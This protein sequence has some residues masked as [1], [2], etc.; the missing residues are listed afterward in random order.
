MGQKVTLD[1]ATMFNKGLEVIE[2]HWLFGVDYDDIDVVIQPQSIIHSMVEYIDGSII[3]QMGNPDM[4]L[5][6]QF[7]FTYPKRMETPSHE[8]MD[9][10]KL[11]AIKILQPDYKVFRSL[12]LAYQ[13]GKAGG[14]MTTVFNAANEEALKAFIRSEIKFLSIFDVVEEVLD[15]WD[16]HDIHSIEDVISA[17]KN[18]R[19]ASASA[20]QRFKC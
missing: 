15:N 3:A 6:I 20:I 2:A 7:A 5:P 12:K 4:R 18:A 11:S 1:S 8:F 16:V 13:A 10:K 14:D 17:D 9:W 19:I